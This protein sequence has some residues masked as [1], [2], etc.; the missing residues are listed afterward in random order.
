MKLDQNKNIALIGFMGAGKSVAAKRLSGLLKKE[1]I[2]T[3]QY[4]EKKEG[5]PIAQIFAEEGEARFR[6]MERAAVKEIGQKRNIIIDCGGGIVLNPDNIRD[7]KKN[8][9]IIYL[10]ASPEMVLKR[11]KDHKHRPLINVPDPLGKI[12][13]L[14]AQRLPLYEQADLTIDTDNKTNAAVCDEILDLLKK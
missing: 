6:A 7:L 4:I 10:S 2:S 12:K 11:I 13:E 8:S 5:R 3:D 14:L 9:I 1:L